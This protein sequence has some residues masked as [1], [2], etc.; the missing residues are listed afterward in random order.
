MKH[1]MIYVHGK[2]GSAAEAEHYKALFPEAEVLGFDYRAQTPWEAKA[3]FPQFFEKQRKQCDRLTLA[4][5]SIGAF[6]SMSSLDET[7]ID[8]AYFISPVVDM[9]NLIENIMLW[10][11]VSERELAEKQE[12]PTQ[13]G[14]TL[15]WAYLTYVREHPVLWQVPTRILYGAH[16]N[17]TSLETI[18]AFAEKTGAELTVMP[19]GEHWFHTEWQMQFLDQWIVT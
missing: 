3:E 9:K 13:F 2:G 15:S 7:L 4:A 18:R 10:T 5:N 11:G 12:I 19:D 16:D 8:R 1:I 14:E 17:L 6:F